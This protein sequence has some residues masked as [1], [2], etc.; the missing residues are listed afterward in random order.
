MSRTFLISISFPRSRR[1]VLGNAATPT[2]QPAAPPLPGAVPTATAGAAQPQPPHGQDQ[3][4]LPPNLENLRDHLARH[5]PAPLGVAHAG[6]VPPATGG[7]FGAPNPP[8]RFAHLFPP[9]TPAQQPPDLN[10]QQAAVPDDSGYNVDVNLPGFR[11]RLRFG[12]N[13]PQAQIAN[14]VPAVNPPVMLPPTAVHPPL[15]TPTVCPPTATTPTPTVAAAAG[16]STTSSASIDPSPEG[17]I[18]PAPEAPETS[19]SDTASAVASSSTLDDEDVQDE[20]TL[21]PREVAVRAALRR[22]ARLNPSSAS[23]SPSSFSATPASAP[24]SSGQTLSPTNVVNELEDGS[25]FFSIP[26]PPTAAGPSSSTSVPPPS[27]AEESSLPAAGPSAMPSSRPRVTLRPLQPIPSPTPLQAL[28]NDI[29]TSSAVPSLPLSPTLSQHQL[30]ILSQQ[31]RHLVEE[32]LRLIDH[33][34]SVLSGLRGEIAR[35]QHS[36]SSKAPAPTPS[37]PNPAVDVS[38]EVLGQASVSSGA[39]DPKGKGKAKEVV[40]PRD[41]PLPAEEEG[42]FETGS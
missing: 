20:T 12:G 40:E 28:L 7:L 10:A 15:P 19:R 3:R 21:T 1:T 39:V 34:D 23:P 41:V 9:P 38:G 16:P 27:Q 18:E 5:P 33:I 11:F 32:R 29:P 36:I 24:S 30:A 22:S 26:P 2:A 6:P 13:V 14:V 17:S 31:T 42:S 25:V 8:A 37:H 35:A 4:P